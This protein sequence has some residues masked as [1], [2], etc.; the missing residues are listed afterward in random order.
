MKSSINTI[1]FL[2]VLSVI[3]LF[4][5]YS[6]SLNEENRWIILD[7]PWFSN[8]FAF[9]TAGGSLASL[10]IV[11]ACELQKYQSLK[12]QT[13]DYIFGQLFSLYTQ[14]TIIHYNTRR[15]LNDISSPVP[16]N[17]IDEIS[18][19]GKMC[20]N[21]LTSIEYI[22][23]YKNNSIGKQLIQYR[24]DSGT[25]I[26][27]FLQNSALLKMAINDD[28]IAF[29]KQGR[30]VLITSNMPK[31]HQTLK[32]IFDDSS[33]VLSFLEKSLGIIEK[34]CKKRY[35]WGELKRKVISVEE[36]FVSSTLDDF[37]KSPTIQFE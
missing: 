9:A 4:V 30:D 36:D 27:L 24:E 22:T 2:A 16:S 28:K 8:S 31:T 20:L 18:N 5:T 6:I 29:L 14:V 33:L 10:L 26:R 37:L 3:L 32:K 19:S 7:T 21:C 35:H 17:L 1:K 23:F 34:E 11:L 13:E 25:R 15:Q 12:R